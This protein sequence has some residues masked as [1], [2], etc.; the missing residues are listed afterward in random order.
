M[1]R[2]AVRLRE[3][4]S[5][6]AALNAI[7]DEMAMDAGRRRALAWTLANEPAKFPSMF[8]LSEQLFLGGG[9]TAAP[10]AASV[11]LNAW[12]MS[13]LGTEGC[14]CTRLTQPGRWWALTGRPQLGIVASAMPDL[15]LHIAARLKELRVPHYYLQLPWATHGFDFNPDGPAGQLTDY[16][17]DRFL[18]VVTP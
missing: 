12:G 15:N 16:A 18:T 8:T 1:A 13:A 10:G 4:L 6:P 17:I 14:I 11:D 5:D 7:A 9:A 3:V 2:G